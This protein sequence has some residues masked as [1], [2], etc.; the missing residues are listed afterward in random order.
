M[1]YTVSFMH[2]GNPGLKT[3]PL[4]EVIIV[5]KPIRQSCQSRSRKLLERTEK[6][7]IDGCSGGMDDNDTQA[8]K[9]QRWP[10]QG[11]LHQRRHDDHGREQLR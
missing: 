8:K 11:M 1:L 10:A 6:Q 7:A 2:L 3:T 5:L 9:Q 4:D